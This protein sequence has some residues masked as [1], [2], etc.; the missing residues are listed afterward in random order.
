MAAAILPRPGTR[1]GPCVGECQH[2][3]CRQTRQEAAQVCAFCGTE[4]GYGV[5]YYRGDRNQL[6]H[7]ACFEDAVEREMKAR[8]Q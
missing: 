8:R 4:I 6:V 1:N 7:A 2:V 5:R 3:D